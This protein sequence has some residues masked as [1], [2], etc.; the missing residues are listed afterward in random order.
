MTN[1]GWNIQLGVQFDQTALKN[2]ES[3]LSSLSKKGLTLDLDIKGMTGSKF[4]ETWK[5]VN[6]EVEKQ[7]KSVEKYTNELGQTVEIVKTLNKDTGKLS[8]VTKTLT[9]NTEKQRKEA[10]KLLAVQEKGLQYEQKVRTAIAKDKNTTLDKQATDDAKA[11]VSA[12]NE[13]RQ[14]MELLHKE[15]LKL[16]V[17]LD[18][19]IDEKNTADAK[20]YM[21]SLVEVRQQMDL[22]EKES[23]KRLSIEQKLEKF[24]TNQLIG[25]DSSKRKYNDIKGVNDELNKYTKTL[26][27][28]SVIE[29]KLINKNTGLETSFD[30]LSL[31]LK[32]INNNAANASVQLQHFQKRNNSLLSALKHNFIKFSEFYL[33]GGAITNSI[34]VGESLIS[35]IKSINDEYTELSKVLNATN[36]ELERYTANSFDF[37]ENLARSGADV[38]NASSELARAGFQLESG[39]KKMTEQSLLL[40]NVADGIDDTSEAAGY[41]IST[42]KAYNLSVQDSNKIVGLYNVLSNNMAINTRDIADIFQH[43]AATMAQT[44]N[45]IEKFASLSVG[46]FEILRDSSRVATGL[47][48]LSLRL[49]GVAEDGSK[50]DGLTPKLQSLY[51]TITEGQVS[52]Q[53]S[54]GELRSTYDIL[55]DLAKLYQSGYFDGKSKELGILITESAGLRQADIMNSILKNWKS[56]EK[57][58]EL[59]TREMSASISSAFIENEKIMESLQARL[60][61]FSNQWQETSYNFISSDLARNVID[62]GTLL[63]KIVDNVGV[64]NTSFLVLAGYLGASGKLALIPAFSRMSESLVQM[65]FNMSGLTLSTNTLTGAVTALNIATGVFIATAFVGALIG[66]RKA[67]DALIVTQEEYI[68]QIDEINQK[69]SDYKSKLSELQEQKEKGLKVDETEIEYLKVMN[70]LLEEKNNNLEK[71][72]AIKN[73]GSDISTGG[74]LADA[75]GALYEIE[76]INKEIEDLMQ[77]TIL[78]GDD[79]SEMISGLQTEVSNLK[80][81]L[82][83]L[84]PILEKDSRIL[85]EDYPN[86]GN[87]A[88]KMIK[89]LL[90]LTIETNAGMASSGDAM[91][92]YWTNRIDSM[93]E[94]ANNAIQ[95]FNDMSEKIDTTTVSLA[96]LASAYETLND[97]EQLSAD[98]MLELISNYPELAMH[99]KN[100]GDLTFKNGEIVKSVFKLKKEA[101]VSELELEAS[102]VD[103]ILN[104]TRS[105]LN[106]LYQK[107]NAY[108]SYAG[109]VAFANSKI[110]ES[111]GQDVDWSGYNNLKAQIE[112]MK[113]ID[114]N[115]IGGSSSS[116]S[117]S[118]TARQETLNTLSET[119]EVEKKLSKIESELSVERAR[120]DEQQSKNSGKILSL[121]EQQKESLHELNNVQ[122]GMRDSMEDEKSTLKALSNPTIE[123]R[124]RIMELEEAIVEMN[125]AISQTSVDWLSAD[126]AAKSFAKSQQDAL[127]EIAKAQKDAQSEI[128][129]LIMDGLKDQDDARKDSLNSIKDALEDEI[130]A[131]EDAEKEKADIRY[132]TAKEGLERQKSLLQE[133]YDEESYQNSLAEKQTNLKALQD[134]S[135]LALSEKEQYDL[136]EE[137][138]ELRK[139][140]A[141]DLAKHELEIAEDAFDDKIDLLEEQY[142]AEIDAMDKQTNKAVESTKIR[143]NEEGRL[144]TYTVKQARERLDAVSDSLE[145]MENST[146]NY[147]F[148]AE[149]IFEGSSNS[150]MDFLKNNLEEFSNY[151]SEMMKELEGTLDTSKGE[152]GATG[153]VSFGGTASR[154]SIDDIEKDDTSSWSSS[155]KDA[156]KNAIDDYQTLIDE[157]SGSIASQLNDMS[158]KDAKGL[159]DQIKET[160]VFSKAEKD[161][162]KNI[163]DAK[164]EWEKNSYDNGGEAYG[165]GL[166]KKATLL[167]ERILDPEQTKAFNDLVYNI[168]PSFKA[169][170]F[171]GLKLNNYKS[172]DVNYN[173]TIKG[174]D[175]STKQAIKKSAQSFADRIQTI[176]ENRGLNTSMVY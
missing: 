59:S 94:S 141:E 135:T 95:T 71:E 86:G 38:M 147:A 72:R 10:E 12:L 92:E 142:D 79:N 112:V 54:N 158:A 44:G 115:N 125:S 22:L 87:K 151:T 109:A 16:D 164:E 146:Q 153:G 17:Q 130:K 55:S 98:T 65:I 11:Y 82:G 122:R 107:Q 64:L 56:V 148:Q 105:E 102:K 3:Q 161:A 60:N 73:S 124:N 101:L 175:F 39:L 108:M 81:E 7:T 93:N 100:T 171:S 29:G 117:S 174:A 156:H 104:S 88:I 23:Q 70:Q 9:D 15:A 49:A 116:S 4:A 20:A 58:M 119:F 139:E 19:A 13:E 118:K 48:S 166:M 51:Q 133:E 37:G 47:R 106:A 160:G 61:L 31:A 169:L 121:Y 25:V 30:E 111:F 33:I 53:D 103:A 74:D 145:E 40:T 35:N 1:N 24:R 152:D 28:V 62:F 41:L 162:V 138:V 131:V 163:V 69:L 96:D 126:E 114:I 75:K 63:L 113:S 155:Q 127:E 2:L 90:G 176:N 144:T 52:I 128:L 172:G 77:Q 170:D 110:M 66:I 134:K 89:E 42:M 129:N 67:T 165:I 99:L 136:N 143:I 123:Q 91:Q 68:E 132:N 83:E 80:V 120:S 18:K 168:L 157:G 5:S 43:S 57:S 159:Y 154:V 140:I 27:N 32:K 8:D 50:I 26:L 21:Q 6:G 173:F 84:L 45:S 36:R 149:K 167:P 85:G 78:Y 76:E 46:A 150:I 14:Q 34:R 137:I 97:G